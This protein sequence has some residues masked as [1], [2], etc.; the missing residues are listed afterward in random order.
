MLREIA[1][2]VFAYLQ[3]DGG[4]FLNNTGFI[5]TGEGVLSIDACATQA[6]TLAYL[7]AIR[8]VTSVPVTT[9]INTHHHGDHTNG[10]RALGAPVIIAHRDCRN[11]LAEQ[12]QEQPPPAGIFGPVEWGDITP[13]LP[14]ICFDHHLDLHAGGRQVRLLHFG[15]PAH[16][17]NDVVAWLPEERVLFAGDLVFNGGTPFAMSGSVTGWLEVLPALAELRPA[18]VVPGHGPPGGPELLGQTATYLTFVRD[19]AASAHAAGLSPLDAAS[20]LDLGQHATLTDPE[21]IVGNLHRALAELSGLPRGGP[22]DVPACFAD[23]IA[24]NGG[25]PLRCLA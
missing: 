14:T 12:A 5:L 23:M 16:T 1:A 4:W 9:L 15:T 21:R 19:A 6:R 24:Y 7:A 18:T 8:K 17:T 20:H 11:L 3:P 10:N 25:A 2:G 22:V 13:A